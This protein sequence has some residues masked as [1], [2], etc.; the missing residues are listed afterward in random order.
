M[1]HARTHRYSRLTHGIKRLLVTLVCVAALFGC[2]GDNTTNNTYVL[3]TST[4]GSLNVNVTPATAS[5][6][7]MVT[8]TGPVSFP[9][10]TFTGNQ[11]LTDLEPGQY[12]AS[13]TATGYG[14]ASSQIN[15]V[16]GQTS[17]ILLALVANASP[18]S[19][20]GALNISV[21]PAAATV[22]VTGP[23]SFSQTFTGN[24][25]INNLA[26]G[27]YTA[28]ATAP[29]FGDGTSQINVVAGQTS[30]ITLALQ[31]TQIIIEA[32]RAV[33]RDGQ[34]NL[35]KLDS[36]NMQSGQFY[37][38]AWLQDE[39][40]G[41]LTT[42]VTSTSGGDPGKPLVDEQKEFAPSFTQNLAG[43][44]VGFMDSTGVVRPVIGA[45]VRWELDQWWFG[46]VNSMQFGTSDDNGIA[47]GYGVFD[48]QAN[49]RTNNSRLAAERFPLIATEYP[50]Y[51]Q[52]GLGTPFTDGFTWVTLF[53]P[54]AKAS[55]RIVAVATINGEEIGKQILY[56]DFAPAP[57]LEITKTVSS[58]IVT[59]A[60]GT[61][62]K[63]VTWTVTVKNTGT[64]DAT[65][66]N[67]SDI[68]ASGAG[69]NY[70]LDTIPAGSSA[71]GDGFTYLFDLPSQFSPAPPQ[72]AQL[73][74]N[75]QSFAVLAASAITNTGATALNGDV[76]ISPNTLSSITGF[77][78]V[79]QLN[80]TVHGAD[81]VAQVAQTALTAAY[82]D[83]A[84]RT[85]TKPVNTAI[86]GILTPG[87]YCYSTSVTTGTSIIL[88]AGGN[89][90]AEFVFQIGSTLDT[91]AGATVS[92]IN[93]ASPCNVYWQVGTSA[94]LG[95]NNFFAGNILAQA[96]IT[97]GT[98]TSI[99]GRALARTAAVTL[100][101]NAINAPLS[102]VAAPGTTKTMSFTATVDA[103]GRYCN[104][105]QIL[106]YDD[107]AGTVTPVDLKQ[108]VCFNALQPVLSIIK[109][110]VADDNTTSQGQSKTVA[111]NVPAKMR[112]RVINS[113]S[114]TAPGVSVNDILDGGALAAYT[115]SSLSSGSTN[116]GDGFDTTIGDLAPGAST[117][118]F[119]TVAASADG[120]YCDTATVS[121][122]S[123]PIG[124]DNACLTVSTP[125]LTITK[126]DT[127]AS[128]L[129]GG[130]YTSMI[131]V[132]ND[133]NATAKN[134]VIKDA[135]GLNSAVN[136]QAI[137]VS[138]SLNGVSGTLAN[139][140]VTA[141][142]VDIPAGGSVTFTV[143]SRIP[144][145]AI[146]GDYCDTAAVTSSNA[147]TPASVSDCVVVPAFAALQTQLV[148]L[149]DPVQVG[150]NVTYFGVLYVEA[151][152]NEGVDQN[153]LEWS[154][155]H[156]GTTGSAVAGLFQVVSTKVYLDSKPVRDPITGM[157][158]S[159]TSSPTA[160]LQTEGTDY[161]VVTTAPGGKQVITMTS[162]VILQPNTALYIVQVANTG[163]A[164][165]G[166]LYNT[167]YTWT[168]YGLDSTIGYVTS[169]SEPTTVL[170]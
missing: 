93:G 32:P 165:G 133:G 170:P 34:G 89:P 162:G 75:A 138:S 77:E 52:T 132:G 24:Q 37:F 98:G 15:V 100:A 35:I 143:V 156:T 112:V 95:A 157:V 161:T 14:N 118:L 96:S 122:T 86:T 72:T 31:A 107:A 59:L 11:F 120:T 46:R 73:L 117:T 116:T 41:I 16:A 130:T 148:D 51:N 149:N 158:L 70:T 136:V 8:V 108:Q 67:L 127:P 167:T 104:E 126:S 97:V 168:S 99:S 134:V 20:V 114:G 12:T 83:L 145:G 135:L 131:V 147:V 146:K 123:G 6:T 102:C 125:H 50:L 29:G 124:S 113:G 43:A 84:G 141:G 68:L 13:A 90:D 3:P 25:F 58:D 10:Q 1:K 151:L 91:P 139:N 4:V 94:T 17:S 85:C 79:V 53:S 119:F 106:S 49:T 115:V 18:G 63:T 21:N 144:L 128:V 40:L 154:F 78:S 5:A 121:D 65:N 56:K 7:A 27:T 105:A 33:Y 129:P 61:D 142:A 137:Y 36:S 87:V 150:N 9:T 74:G 2:K 57:K 39:P 164:T 45:D 64:G 160:L 19:T 81:A 28:K 155:G 163:T 82:V 80:G 103:A 62:T 22:V 48:D 38:Y 140:I 92:L 109:D 47:T 23:S 153:S 55:A 71:A 169:K 166:A 66:V 111:A 101:A 26:P 159:D 42:K 88:D 30:S 76:G 60:S 69:A 110:F 44:W 152:S 54:D